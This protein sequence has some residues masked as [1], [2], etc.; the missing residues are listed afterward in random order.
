M[1]ASPD[2]LTY[3]IL[4]WI[5]N[6]FISTLNMKKLRLREFNHIDQVQLINVWCW[7]SILVFYLLVPDS[8]R[9]F[10]NFS[11]FS[12]DCKKIS[13]HWAN[14]GVKNKDLFLIKTGFK[15][16]KPKPQLSL[17]ILFCSSHFFNGNALAKTCLFFC[18]IIPKEASTKQKAWTQWL[19]IFKKR[20]D[21]L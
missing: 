7:A 20:G 3:I 9:I 11:E 5:K 17:N 14:I 4:L 15:I 16:A 19:F 13:S 12:Q 2:A 1:I 10:G 18:Q 8:L 21:S 6:D